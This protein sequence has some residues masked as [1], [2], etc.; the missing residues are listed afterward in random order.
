M[1]NS[2]STNNQWMTLNDQVQYMCKLN[3][4][5]LSFFLNMSGV[6]PNLCSHQVTDKMTK[7]GISAVVVVIAISLAFSQTARTALSITLLP[8]TIVAEQLGLVSL[9]SSHAVH[10]LLKLSKSGNHWRGRIAVRREQGH[11][12]EESVALSRKG[13]REPVSNA[14][15]R[16]LGHSDSWKSVISTTSVAEG[17]PAMFFRGLSGIRNSQGENEKH[18][19]INKLA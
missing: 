3:L 5:S 9:W 14:R 11:L 17:R 13:G 15:R 16:T 19:E 6:A 12:H 7:V 8:L 18:H 1:N 2:V 10:P 4:S